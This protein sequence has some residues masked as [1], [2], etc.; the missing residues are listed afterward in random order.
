MS[1]FLSQIQCDE[2][3]Y[4]PTAEDIAE[5]CRWLELFFKL[6]EEQGCEPPENYIG[7]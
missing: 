7:E 4:E 5:H 6:E 3:P 2:L 1:D